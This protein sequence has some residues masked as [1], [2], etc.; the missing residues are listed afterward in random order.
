[1]TSARHIRMNQK[2]IETLRELVETSEVF[3][4]RKSYNFDCQFQK[5]LTEYRL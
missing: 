2:M 5:P 4:Q 3:G 1:M